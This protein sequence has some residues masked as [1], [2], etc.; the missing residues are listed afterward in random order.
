[1]CSVDPICK[2]QKKTKENETKNLATRFPNVI[3]SELEKT[4]FQNWK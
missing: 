4:D 2:P 3:G 1:M